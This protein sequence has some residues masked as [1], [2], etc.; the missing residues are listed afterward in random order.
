MAQE[1]WETL[2]T[3]FQ[4]ISPISISR[5]ILN[6][7]KIQLS[8][9]TNIY[10]YCGKYQESYDAVCSFIGD[11]CELPA[12]SAKM[13]LKAGFF[14]GMGDEYSSL[15]STIETEWKERESDLAKSILRL[16]RFSNIQKKKRPNCK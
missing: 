3:T 2:K 5:L 6:T 10:D 12:K 7:T 15:I 16:I 4:H 8:D 13:L 9:C 11:K 1:M 14:T